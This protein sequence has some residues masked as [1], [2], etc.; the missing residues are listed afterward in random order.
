MELAKKFKEFS[1]F[2]KLSPNMSKLEIAHIGGLKRV[3]TAV[4]GMKNIDLKSEFHL[5][6]K[7]FL[8]TSVIALQK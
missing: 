8:F 2:V 3:E 7:T 6:K 4:C 5:S 1:Y